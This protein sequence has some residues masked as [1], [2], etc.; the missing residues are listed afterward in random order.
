[1]TYDVAWADPLTLGGDPVA[2]TFTTEDGKAS[3][4][5]GVFV[6]IGGGKTAAVIVRKDGDADLAP[7]AASGDT[8]IF[9]S[10]AGSDGQA[11]AEISGA[12]IADG[13]KGTYEWNFED[14]TPGPASLTT[15]C[16]PTDEGLHAECELAGS[17]EK[18][19]GRYVATYQPGEDGRGLYVH[20]PQIKS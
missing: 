15:T 9:V 3:E 8:P 1:M 12:D 13:L 20:V 4:G 11:P 10:Y 17:D 19:D 6:R 18:S 7:L 14:G 16:T 5:E 2:C